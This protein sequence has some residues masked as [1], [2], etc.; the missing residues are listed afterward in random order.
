MTVKITIPLI[1]KVTIKTGFGRT[2]GIRENLHA[3]AEHCSQHRVMF[4]KRAYRRVEKC[5]ADIQ[6]DIFRGVAFYDGALFARHH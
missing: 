2:F 6:F 5:P 4:C 3:S 1:S